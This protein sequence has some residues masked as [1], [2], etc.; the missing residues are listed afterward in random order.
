LIRLTSII[1]WYL[2]CI[3]WKTIVKCFRL[4]YLR[5]F[6]K[7]PWLIKWTWDRFSI[8]YNKQ[9]KSNIQSFVLTEWSNGAESCIHFLW[10][11]RSLNISCRSMSRPFTREYCFSLC[12]TGFSFLL[13]NI[14]FDGQ[15]RF[16]F[17]SILPRK[18][19]YNTVSGVI[20]PQMRPLSSSASKHSP[21]NRQIIINNLNK[22]IVCITSNFLSE[23]RD[24]RL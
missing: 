18:S 5:V 24:Y 11:S 20:D 14:N 2:K 3:Y 1:I 12:T 10:L 23:L 13:M 8:I 22:S 6:F 16:Y 17:I 21:R 19:V 7:I 15:S 9:R 4:T